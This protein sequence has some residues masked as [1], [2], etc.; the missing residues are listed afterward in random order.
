MTGDSAAD[1]T[2]ARL[3]HRWRRD[4][5]AETF[6]SLLNRYL[7]ERLLYRLGR[8]SQRDRFILKGALLFALWG[9]APHR[10]TRD[11]DPPARVI[12]IRRVSPPLA[13]TSARRA[14]TM[15]WRS[16]PTRCGRWR[17]ARMPPTP[18]CV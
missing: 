8:S 15:A 13:G 7:L 12:R 18:A 6:E 10:A 1:S 14:A 16:A 4:G 3:L 17:C 11:I 5:Q 9:G 2:K